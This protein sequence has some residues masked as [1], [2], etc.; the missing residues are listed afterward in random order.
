MRTAMVRCADTDELLGLPV[1]LNIQRRHPERALRRKFPRSRY[2]PIIPIVP[3][4]LEGLVVATQ[5]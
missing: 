4:S 5:L 3:P 1:A 2:Y